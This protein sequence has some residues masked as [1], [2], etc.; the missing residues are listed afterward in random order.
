[1]AVA[2]L[3]SGY[4]A[5]AQSIVLDGTATTLN[6]GSSCASSPCFIDGGTTSGSNLLHTFQQFNVDTGTVVVFVDP[7]VENIIGQ[8]TSLGNNNIS[9]IDGVLGVTGANANLFLI[10]PNG[11]V[12]GENA[13]L[14]VPGSFI[15]STA[16]DITFDSDIIASGDPNIVPILTVST[17]VGLQLGT[18][19]GD[20]TVSTL[21]PGGFAPLNVSDGQT[22]ALVGRNVDFTSEAIVQAVDNSG[23]TG[24]TIHIHASERLSTDNSSIENAVIGTGD[25]SNQ[26]ILDAP[27]IDLGAGTQI[28]LVGGPSSNGELGKIDIIAETLTFDATNAPIDPNTGEPRDSLIL[29][30]SLSGSTV[31][32]GDVNVQT[33][34]LRLI[35]GARI[36]SRT[37]G[38]G[39]AG[40]VTVQNTGTIEITGFGDGEPS[41]IASTA[42]TPT[43][44]AG[45]SVTIDTAQ[46]I[47]SGG[48]QISTGTRSDGAAGNLTVNASELIALEGNTTEGRSGLFANAVE[49]AGTGGDITVDTPYLTLRDG[50]TINV[51]NSPSSTTSSFSDGTGAAGSIFVQ[52]AEVILMDGESILTAE[53][54]DGTGANISLEADAV[55]LNN[56]S[57][58]TTSAKGD[59]EG[60]NI[61]IN[62]G[63]LLAIADSDITANAVNSFGGKIS[64]D[65]QGII[66]SEF[67]TVLT[68]ENDITAFSEQGAEFSGE[69]LLTTPEVD[70]IQGVTELPQTLVNNNQIQTAC[71]PVGNNT[72][73]ISG[74]GGVPQDARYT[75]N[76]S[77]NNLWQDVRLTDETSEDLADDQRIISDGL[78]DKSSDDIT[79]LEAQQWS[80]DDIG[81][82][83]LT[84]S[85]SS[86]G[87]LQPTG[88]LQA[89]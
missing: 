19:S 41:G 59:A 36:E 87:N 40:D 31:E 30:A 48:G 34:T 49:S 20:I 18:T 52:N 21:S 28:T 69:V 79:L 37:L 75:I 81:Q 4:S 60:G 35:N 47:V 65:A 39:S 15:A 24:S 9:T 10:N 6:G 82:V 29:A 16:E 42:I 43:A 62:T 78:L 26:I 67:R 85:K 70:P 68:S 51:S 54:V 44:G 84:A 88:C 8:I 12:F 77:S 45:G 55:V 53:T 56:G 61:S 7:G 66:G 63:V 25:G 86:I 58:I 71:A 14:V 38:T 1:M 23:F 89:S 80:I 5:L 33:D 17:P 64:I 46:L 22:L 3:F 50:S 72:F 32:S 27:T 83:H 11:I 73:V 2:S 76:S 13:R 74:Q 57:G